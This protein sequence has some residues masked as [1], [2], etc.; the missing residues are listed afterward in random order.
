MSIKDAK[1]RGTKCLNCNTPLDISERY[2]HFCGQ[3]NST[4]KVA[5]SDF[6]EEFFANFYAYDSRIKNTFSFLFTKPAFVAK[7][8][9]LGRRQTFA[10]PF[11]LFLSIVIIYFLFASITSKS[12]D[13]LFSQKENPTIKDTITQKVYSLDEIKNTNYI[14]GKIHKIENFYTLISKDKFITYE[15]AIEKLKYKNNSENKYLFKRAYLYKDLENNGWK[16]ELGKSFREKRPFII[17]LL[18]PFLSIAFYV[19]FKN[20]IYSYTDSLIFIYTLATVLYIKFFIDTFFLNLLSINIST[21]SLLLFLYY[22]YKSLRKFY[23]LNRWKTIYKF[24]ILNIV[25]FILGFPLILGTL[26][27]V[28]LI[29]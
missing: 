27:L 17:F 20:K 24:V 4:K 15:E 11:R 5:V 29:T 21:I 10:N 23:N 7:Q 1:Y 22:F 8:I 14:N 18:L 2:C 3:L 19:S 28:F 13:R 6:I 12:D 25:T 9:I 26:L 16:S